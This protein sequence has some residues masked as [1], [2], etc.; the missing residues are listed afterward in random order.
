[1][2]VEVLGNEIMFCVFINKIHVPSSNLELNNGLQT[3]FINRT[4]TNTLNNLILHIQ[5]MKL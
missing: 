5:F 4:I 1:M 3:Q 2:E